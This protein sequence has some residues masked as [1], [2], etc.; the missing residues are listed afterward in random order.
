MA[1]ISDDKF[2]IKVIPRYTNWWTFDFEFFYNDK[3]IFN[4]EITK[5]GIFEGDEYEN[6]E[7]LHV[8]EKA[9]K[10]KIDGEIFGWS[11]WETEVEVEI[12]AIIKNFDEGMDGSFDF[13]VFVGEIC[14]TE[15]ET[16]YGFQNAGVKLFV[17]R[18]GLKKFYNELKSEMQKVPNAPA[19]Q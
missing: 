10:S 19:I 6:L 5:N 4:P 8:I 1:I 12:K 7:F 9:A 14:F 17:D 11:A 2:K 18:E 13:V 15:G 16:K 3:P